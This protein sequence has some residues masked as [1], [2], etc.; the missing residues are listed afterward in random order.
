MLLLLLL[1]A[2]VRTW[3]ALQTEIPDRDAAH[4]LW[5]AQG[6]PV[7]EPERLFRSVFHPVFPALVGLLMWIAPTLDPV[8]AGQTISCAC[9]VLAVVP[10]YLVTLRVGG[11]QAG[12]F[13][14]LA[15]ALGTWFTRHPADALSEGVFHLCVAGAAALLVC[16]RRAGAACGAGVLAA[17]AYGTRPEGATLI[18]VGVW[19]VWRALPH[20]CVAAFLGGAALAVLLPLGWA[21]LGPGFTLTPKA[22]FTW[23][24]GAGDPIAGGVGHY[25]RELVRMPGAFVEAFGYGVAALVLVGIWWRRRVPAQER[26][27]LLAPFVVQCLVVPALFAHWRFLSGY[28]VLLLPFAGIAWA[29]LGAWLSRHGRL[30]V[31]AVLLLL[32]ARELALLPGVRRADRVVERT[33]GAW[34]GQQ[35]RPGERVASDMPRLDFFAGV[36]PGPPRPILAAELEAAAATGDARFIV[37]VEGRMRVDPAV[38]RAVGLDEVALPDE[39]RSEDRRIRVFARR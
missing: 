15:F 8:V 4:Y 24:V 18:L 7:G 25:A 5:M 22:G 26:T 3:V 39:L 35:L 32:F 27:L 38:L 28:G 6:I 31:A 34:L 2:C 13:S 21:A 11:T 37:W 33:L 12:W 9:S 16:S 10:L 29:A 17:L 23:A 30:A 1:A 36:E 19:Y 20:A 14:A